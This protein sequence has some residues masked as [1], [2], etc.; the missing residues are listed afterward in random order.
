MGFERS[1]VHQFASWPNSINSWNG[2]ART[3]SGFASHPVFFLLIH[4]VNKPHCFLRPLNFL[5]LLSM[6]LIGSS[7]PVFDVYLIPLTHVTHA[8]IK[9]QNTIVS[10][11]MPHRDLL[12]TLCWESGSSLTVRYALT[13]L[14]LPTWI[15]NMHA[16]AII[17]W[18]F[19]VMLHFSLSKLRTFH[20]MYALHVLYPF[21]TWRILSKGVTDL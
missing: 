8:K 20:C 11:P 15:A 17:M 21:T 18:P 19:C 7:H 4:L 14:A 16:I 12:A 10:F 1:S 9:A 3:A 2:F 5:H 6:L 13:Y